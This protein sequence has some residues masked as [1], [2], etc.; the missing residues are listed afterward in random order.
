MQ[1]IITHGTL[2]RT[3]VLHVGRLQF[4]AAL[5]A[6]LLLLGFA[7]GAAW[8]LVAA[9]AAGGGWTGITV[10]AG[11]EQR[12]R[13]LRENLDA[14]ARRIGEMQAKLVK[15]EAMGERVS[16]LAGV[17]ADEFAEATRAAAGSQGGPFVPAQTPS[18]EQLDALVGAIDRQSDHS[19]DLYTYIEARLSEKRLQALMIPTSRPVEGG[20]GSGFGFR[21]DPFS[22]HNAL[23]TGLDFPADAG[24]PIWAAAGGVVLSAGAHPAYGRMLE[25][26]HGNGVVTRYAHTAKVHVKAGDIV[27]RGQR[28]ADVGNSGRSTGPHLHF[29]VLVDGAPQDPVKFLAG[30]PGLAERVAR[31]HR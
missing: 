1:L 4:A 31:K 12:D 26:D 5:G 23:H 21:A 27:R 29:E 18:F 13:Y 17:R 8:Y 2:A 24:T 30:G 28:V 19:S 9:K 11:T 20:V 7:V 16:G 25:I 3:R 15:L 10:A 14:M 22:G 6:L